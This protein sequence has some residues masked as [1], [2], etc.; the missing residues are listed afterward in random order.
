[1]S[2]IFGKH[3]SCVG[4]LHIVGMMYFYKYWP[5]VCFVP[6]DSKVTEAEG[7]SSV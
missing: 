2:A 1:M 7:I 5:L 3:L 4:T 6:P